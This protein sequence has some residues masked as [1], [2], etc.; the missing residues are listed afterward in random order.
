M[1]MSV[2]LL[3]AGVCPIPT[4]RMERDPC[5]TIRHAICPLFTNGN[6]AAPIP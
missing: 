6:H 1:A 3:H 2:L 4:G 5:Y